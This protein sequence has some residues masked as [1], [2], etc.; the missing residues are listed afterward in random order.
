MPP[1]PLSY[2]YIDNPY[3]VDV[4]KTCSDNKDILDQYID[5][6][7]ICNSDMPTFMFGVRY[8]LV[9]EFTQKRNITKRHPYYKN[10]WITCILSTYLNDNRPTLYIPYIA[11]FPLSK[12]DKTLLYLRHREI[13]Y[14]K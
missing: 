5:A 10:N 12:P 3:R 6:N 11:Y 4:L 13:G 2:Y 8:A 1:P 7:K 9:R 14:C